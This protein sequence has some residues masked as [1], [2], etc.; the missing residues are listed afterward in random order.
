MQARL[1]FFRDKDDKG[2][3]I[4][5]RLVCDTLTPIQTYWN[6]VGDGHGFLLESIPGSYS[7]IGR[8]SDPDIIIIDQGSP[9]P[10]SMIPLKGAGLCFEQN[11][12]PPFIGG[13]VGYMGYDMARGIENLPRPKIPSGFPDAM[14]GRVDTLV[15]FDH[16]RQSISLIHAIAE[17]DVGHKEAQS[18]AEDAFRGLEDALYSRSAMPIV[19]APK[20]CGIQTVSIDDEGFVDAVSK[21]KQYIKDGHL[22]IGVTYRIKATEVTDNAEQPEQ[23]RC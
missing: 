17:A 15:V 8:F 6:L 12:L 5:K 13:Y 16:F 2:I 7:F 22:K 14:L 20:P 4:M 11:G 1:Q 9:D 10:W 21:T 23:T 18:R 19:Q 3:V